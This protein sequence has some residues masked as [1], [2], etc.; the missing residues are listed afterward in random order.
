MSALP[1]SHQHTNYAASVWSYHCFQA[2]GIYMNSCYILVFILFLSSLRQH[3]DRVSTVPENLEFASFLLRSGKKKTLNLFQKTEN[4]GFNTFKCIG[5]AMQKPPWTSH[6][7]I[8]TMDRHLLEWWGPCMSR[9]L[10][11]A[12]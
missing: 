4:V 1:L 5:K 3:S 7:A 2:D 8:L 6:L 11:C 12:C 9:T 10:W